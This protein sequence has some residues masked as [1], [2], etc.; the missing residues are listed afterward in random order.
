MTEKCEHC[1]MDCSN[2]KCEEKKGKKCCGDC[3][4]EKKPKE[5]KKTNTCEFC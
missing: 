3:C 4:E 2:G 1:G 5:K